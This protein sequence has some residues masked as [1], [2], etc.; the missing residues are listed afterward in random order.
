MIEQL[1]NSK[2]TKHLKEK[3]LLSNNNG[4]INFKFK[5]NEYT[6]KN[7]KSIHNIDILQVYFDKLDIL[8]TEIN[9][10]PKT[11]QTIFFIITI[12]ITDL[13]K[14]LTLLSEIKPMNEKHTHEFIITLIDIINIINLGITIGLYNFLGE[15]ENNPKIIQELK[16]K[17]KYDDYKYES[18]VEDYKYHVLNLFNLMLRIFDD[19]YFTDLNFIQP[20]NKM[21]V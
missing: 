6:V 21:V 16:V 10:I 15:I 4:I 20:I 1:L 9:E 18:F 19:E 3:Y 14:A 17:Y 13:P 11:I 7:F 12:A 5:N 8:V 2:I